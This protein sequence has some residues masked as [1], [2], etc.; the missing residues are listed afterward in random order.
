M[1]AF[2]ISGTWWL[3][4]QWKGMQNRGFW[5]VHQPTRSW[6]LLGPAG[7]AVPGNPALPGHHQAWSALASQPGLQILYPLALPPRSCTCSMMARSNCTWLSLSLGT[8]PEG[9]SKWRT[10]GPLA[11]VDYVL[12]GL[13]TPRG[14]E[15]STV[16]QSQVPELPHQNN[17]SLPLSPSSPGLLSQDPNKERPYVVGS[18]KVQPVWKTDFFIEVSICLSY[19]SAIPFLD[20]YPKQME[21]CPQKDLL[22][23]YS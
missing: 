5:P 9:I 16:C 14:R 2:T 21:M 17:L 19:D 6:S 8:M 13:I 20:I 11:P 23:V 10:I 12:N 15:K 3:L 18:S 22:Y 4:A 1:A 7:H